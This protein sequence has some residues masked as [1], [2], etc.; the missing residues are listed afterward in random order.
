MHGNTLHHTTPHCT[1]PY[2]TTLQHSATLLPCPFLGSMRAHYCES[3]CCSVMQSVAV[4]FSVMQCA[5]VHIST[6]TYTTLFAGQHESETSRGQVLAKQHIATR[7]NAW[8]HTHCTFRRHSA[9]HGTTL[10]HTALRCT[11]LHHITSHRS[12]SQP[13]HLHG[14]IIVCHRDAVCYN[15]LHR[16][17]VYCSVLQ[18]VAV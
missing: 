4:Y 1:A 10:H 12:A 17:A 13:R 14:G 8:H 6:H 5:T 16:A 9:P 2:H 11:S 18:Y 15:V 3:V 7:C